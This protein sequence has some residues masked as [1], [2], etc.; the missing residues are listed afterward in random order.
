MLLPF[1]LDDFQHRLKPKTL[2]YRPYLLPV[3][4]AA[5]RHLHYLGGVALAVLVSLPPFAEEAGEGRVIH[6]NIRR[7]RMIVSVVSRLTAGRWSATLLVPVSEAEHYPVTGL[8]RPGTAC[9]LNAFCLQIQEFAGKI[10]YVTY[11]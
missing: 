5:L 4:Q 1:H 3:L 6:D 2:R 11:Y 7:L 10:N 9:D 8:K